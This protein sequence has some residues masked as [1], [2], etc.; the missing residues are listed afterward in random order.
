MTTEASA[1]HDCGG[2]SHSRDALP[3]KGLGP[4]ARVTVN[5]LT[6]TVPNVASGRPDHP[7]AAGRAVS[8][9]AP[10]AGRPVLALAAG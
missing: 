7:L 5:R 6:F 8:L 1:N 4:G 3:G 10:R 2:F 9:S